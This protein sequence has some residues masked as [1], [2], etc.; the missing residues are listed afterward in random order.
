MPRERVN[1][2][3]EELQERKWPIF[4]VTMVGLFMALVDVTI[5]NIAIPTLIQEHGTGI[6]TVSWVLN[7]YSLVLA[8]LL[9]SMGR[10]ADQFGRKKF[11][12]IG[13]SI[14]TPRQ[15][16]FGLSLLAIVANAAAALGPLIGGLVLEAGAW[17]W[18][19]FINVPIGI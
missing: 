8:I 11:F 15:R 5:V 13:M 4:A 14:F 9:I 1:P 7:A 19:F 2:T 6:S 3:A 18:I 10:L 17:G 12:L 16:G